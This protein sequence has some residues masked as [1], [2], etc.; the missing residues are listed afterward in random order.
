MKGASLKTTITHLI[1][2]AKPCEQESEMHA[3]TSK[4]MY[5]VFLGTEMMKRLESYFWI[6]QITGAK[7]R[8]KHMHFVLKWPQL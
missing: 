7:I 4:G 8:I 5:P 2:Q 1:I 3:A 6:G